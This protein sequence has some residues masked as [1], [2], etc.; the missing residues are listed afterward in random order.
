[1][2]KNKTKDDEVLK[3]GQ[4][5]SSLDD[6]SQ[7]GHNKADENLK[8]PTLKDETLQAELE[9]LCEKASNPILQ[10][11]NVSDEE[12]AKIF[13]PEDGARLE[14]L[15]NQ[16]MQEIEDQAKDDQQKIDD[17][18]KDNQDK[19]S[20]EDTEAQKKTDDEARKKIDAETI[21]AIKDKKVVLVSVSEMEKIKKRDGI[22]MSAIRFLASKALSQQEFSDFQTTFPELF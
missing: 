7:M 21:K 11:V 3:A 15:Q 4:G 9:T 17:T 13:S 12:K 22:Q 10:D 20:N 19:G 14:A 18:A 6:E 2:A 16:L 8:T 5:N 1:M